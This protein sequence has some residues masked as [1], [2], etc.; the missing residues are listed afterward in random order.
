MQHRGAVHL[1]DSVSDSGVTPDFFKFPCDMPGPFFALRFVELWRRSNFASA[2]VSRNALDRSSGRDTSTV[3][4]GRVMSSSSEQRSPIVR[5]FE[6]FFQ[7]QNIK[8]MLGVGMMILIGSSLMLVTSHWD[9][10][11]PLWKSV[12]LLGYTLGVHIAGQVSY[13]S[14]ALR[15]TGTVLMALTVLLIPLGFHA[16][17]WNFSEDFGQQI[18]VAAFVCR[19]LCFR[20]RGVAEDL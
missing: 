13:H 1:S 6:T 10:Y 7:E 19:Q 9:A 18:D 14:L 20:S 12:I 4:V 11:T 5:F 17:R 3:A 2:M 16:L 8:W 15:K